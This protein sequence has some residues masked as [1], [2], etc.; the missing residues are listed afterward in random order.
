MTEV[1]KINSLNTIR[2]IAAIQVVYGHTMAHLQLPAIPIMGAVLNFFQGVPIFFTMSGFL[3]WGSI[4]RSR[5]YS[6]Y[7]SKRFWRIYPELWVAVAVELIVL[8][9][10]Y[11][12]PIDKIQVGIFAITQS[13]FFQFW[14]PECLRGYGCGTPNGA[15]WTICV[16][17]QFYFIAF[18]LYKLLHNKH[19]LWWV[20]AI[21]LSLILAA[22][23]PLIS[24]QLPEVVSKLYSQTI[25]PYGW[26]FVIPSFVAE[27]KDIVLPVLKKYW[28]AFLAV[29]LFANTFSLDIVV[30]KYL[31]IR[32]L[33][34]FLGLT[35]LAYAIPQL[36]V[37]IDISYAVYIYHMTIVNAF[38][39]M[40]WMKSIWLYV[41]I[42]VLT[43]FISWISTVTVGNWSKK[44]KQKK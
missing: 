7:L 22:G 31:L 12:Q 21:F 29:V 3:I 38:I 41:V 5:N 30:G 35:G 26:M 10:L 28:W 4:G 32:T 40:G 6:E 20:I 19:I 36:N 18:F 42:L 17:I 27:K 15:L 37:R 1:L 43:C 14:T 25:I 11:H 23:T 24:A 16:L 9:L 2:L 33:F 44:K 39:A 8:M 34:L 13:T